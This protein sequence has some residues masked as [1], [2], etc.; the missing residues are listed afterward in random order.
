MLDEFLKD[1]SLVE[2]VL[3][4]LISLNQMVEYNYDLILECKMVIFL[5]KLKE[6]KGNYKEALK[7]LIKIKS[8]IRNHRNQL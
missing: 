8:K 7:Y 6:M 2:E 1:S 3:D 4:I 5:S